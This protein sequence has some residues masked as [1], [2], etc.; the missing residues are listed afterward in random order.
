MCKCLSLHEAFSLSFH[1]GIYPV[2][3]CC[4]SDYH[5]VYHHIFNI[6]KPY[7]TLPPWDNWNSRH[8]PL[9]TASVQRNSVS[10]TQHMYE[11]TLRCMHVPTLRCMHVPTLMCMHV[12]MLM[13]MHVPTLMCMHVPTLRYMHVPTPRC[14]HVPTLRCMHVPTLRCMHVPTLMCM[15]VPTLRC[16]HVSTL[17]CMHVPTLMCMHVPMLMCM[18]VPTLRCMHVHVPTLIYYVH[19]PILR[20][21]CCLIQFTH[22]I[23]DSACFV[24]LCL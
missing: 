17:R 15:H 8:V 5:W 16:M 2:D 7:P 10:Y 11:P 1:A 24:L 12:P 9:V 6:S 3:L 18:H 4:C 21:Y 19:A 23:T 14:M 20:L 22:Y 13:C